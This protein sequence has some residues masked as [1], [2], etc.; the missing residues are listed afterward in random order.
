MLAT[1]EDPIPSWMMGIQGL[2]A[3][4]L[5]AGIGVI[6]TLKMKDEVAARIV[7]VDYVVNNMMA[8]PLDVEENKNYKSTK[9]YNMVGSDENNCTWK[10]L[11]DTLTKYNRKYPFSAGIWYPFL[12]PSENQLIYKLKVFF[13]HTMFAHFADTM[14]ILFRRKPM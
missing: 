8:I 14:L 10:Q 12:S 7:P 9:I 2:A 11:V 6:R 4:A 13:F 3:V 1:Y 5:G